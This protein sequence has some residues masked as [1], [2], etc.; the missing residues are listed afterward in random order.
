[1]L[2]LGSSRGLLEFDR[3]AG[4]FKHYQADPDKPQSLSHGM[5]SALAEDQAGA[6]WV[7]TAGG[8]NRF[9]RATR[10]FTRF[11][12]K[13]GLPS[14]VINSI[15]NDEGGNLWLGTNKGLARFDPRTGRCRNCDSSDGLQSSEFNP[16]AALRGA[17]GELFFGG[18]NGLNHFFPER[19]K[20]SDHR[21]PVVITSFRKFEHEASLDRP[22]W[23]TEELRLS[24]RDYVISFEFAA[25]DYR[26]PRKLQY[27]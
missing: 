9:D 5:V 11:T 3:A 18:V 17:G 20:D 12:L 25:L 24:H 19:I 10:T 22:I 23:A 7:G 2:W 21:P 1:V 26:N 15:L 27:A 4:Q 16:G 14:E 8:L 6:L 13:E